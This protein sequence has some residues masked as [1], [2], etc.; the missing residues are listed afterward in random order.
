M[1]INQKAFGLAASLMLVACATTPAPL[2]APELKYAAPSECPS[3]LDMSQAVGLPD[4][5][6][7]VRKMYRNRTLLMTGQMEKD[8]Q[9]LVE[10]G[11]KSSPAIVFLLPTDLTGEVI[12]AGSVL[13]PNSI[14]AADVSTLDANGNTVRSFPRES[15]LFQGTQYG[16]QFRPKENETF[17]LIKAAHELIGDARETTELSVGSQ[18]V[19]LV[20]GS[21]YGSGTNLVGSQ[22]SYQR[23]YAYDGAVSVRVVFPKQEVAE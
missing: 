23:I 18:N 2:L 21:S 4:D 8:S 9:C 20:V 5:E 12:Y 14:F 15:F 6:K 3:S 19:S 16:V 1:S 11:G 22:T 7:K 17:V 13:D 10:D